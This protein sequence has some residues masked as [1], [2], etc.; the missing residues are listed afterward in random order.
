M[1]VHNSVKVAANPARMTS[2][3]PDLAAVQGGPP[4]DAP[5]D[6]QL[7][8]Y[9]DGP[10]A[11]WRIVGWARPTQGD[12]K[13]VE[14]R[15]AEDGIDLSAARAE[16]FRGDLLAAGIGDGH[17]GF[18]LPLPAKLFDG[19]R[20]KLSVHVHG[21]NGPNLLDS[22]DIA[23]PS[24]PPTTIDDHESATTSVSA[25][26]REVLRRH[27]PTVHNDM[28]LYARELTKT[29]KDIVNTYDYSTALGLLYVHVLRRHIDEGGLQS[30]IHRLAV[31]PAELSKIVYEVLDSD[32]T[33]ARYHDN[34]D[35]GF[36]DLGPLLAWTGLRV[37]ERPIL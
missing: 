36:P 10:D 37:P 35:Q 3:V 32:E 7:S 33:R 9:V 21:T 19:K 26:V 13:R 29:L 1:P 30:R 15:L 31:D 4:P 12:D 2:H 18:L 20:H 17:Y 25:M 28:H 24:R 16:R 8:G 27:R 6:I 5:A 23:L 11:K 22:L 14:V 34:Q